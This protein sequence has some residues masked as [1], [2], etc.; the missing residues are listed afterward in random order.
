[1]VCH[2]TCRGGKQATKLPGGWV[3]VLGLMPITVVVGVGVETGVWDM[4]GCW[5]WGSTG[6]VAMEMG[7]WD[8]TGSWCCGRTGGVVMETGVCDMIG[9]W[10]WGRTG[11]V[12]METGVWDM[13]GCWCWDRTGGVVMAGRLGIGGEGNWLKISRPIAGIPL[14]DKRKKDS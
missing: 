6:G 3:L 4:T 11:G 9:C 12:V 8:M 13:I 1:M 7:I 10:C 5:C 2:I 14:W